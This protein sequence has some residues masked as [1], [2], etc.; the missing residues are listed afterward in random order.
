MPILVVQ[1]AGTSVKEIEG[2]YSHV[3]T[4]MTT[5][6]FNE[7]VLKMYEDGSFEFVPRTRED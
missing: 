6:M 4:E 7:K 1:A 3:M 5:M 2:T